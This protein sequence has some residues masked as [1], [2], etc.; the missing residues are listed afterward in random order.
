MDQIS[1]Q[2]IRRFPR[3]ATGRE[4]AAF[5]KVLWSKTNLKLK[6]KKKPPSVEFCFDLPLPQ[7]IARLYPSVKTLFFGPGADAFEKDLS[8]A[9]WGVSSGKKVSNFIPNLLHLVYRNAINRWLERAWKAVPGRTKKEISDY[10]D[11]ATKKRGKQ[12]DAIAALWAVHRFE[13]LQKQLKSL[14]NSYALKKFDRPSMWRRAES[15]V[16]RDVL[17]KTLKTLVGNENIDAI[18]VDRR[19]TEERIALVMLRIEFD[20]KYPEES[21]RGITLK[22]YLSL[23]E[24]LRLA[25]S[26][27]PKPHVIRSSS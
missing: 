5:K 15:I 12:P 4:T 6:V 26:A 14:R 18:F 27:V 8:R 2:P 24:E 1:Q 19:V 11:Q 7:D 23:G 13:S 3:L 16:T 10:E 9:Y 21:N 17:S 22:K 25:L 20:Q